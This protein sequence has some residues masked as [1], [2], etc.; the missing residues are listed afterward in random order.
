[1]WRLIA[2]VPGPVLPQHFLHN[3]LFETLKELKFQSIRLLVHRGADA[4]QGPASAAA[5]GMGQP[6]NN[7][8][9]GAL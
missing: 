4:A 6:A 7:A 9:Q 5:G 2:Q 3:V 1:M 8:R